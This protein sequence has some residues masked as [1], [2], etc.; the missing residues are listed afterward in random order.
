MP[1]LTKGA[2]QPKQV[3]VRLSFVR[4]ETGDPVAGLVVNIFAD[5]PKNQGPRL[6]SLQTDRAGYASYKF[7]RSLLAGN[8]RLTVA[9]G[10]S[11][12]Q[13]LVLNVADLLAGNDAH[14]IRLD[15][16][17][18]SVAT[19]GP[20]LGL[21]SVISP[22]PK[23]AALSPASVGLIPQLQAS[24]GLC[25]QLMPTTLDGRRFQAV[26]VVPDDI[27]NPT[28]LVCGDASPPL[29]VQIVTGKLLEYEIVWNPR[30]VVLGDLLNSITLA[31]C[32]QVNVAVADWMRRET[33]S[34][35]EDTQL[36]E[37]LYQQMDHDRLITEAMN[38]S[39]KKKSLSLAVGFSAPI[40]EKLNITGA[41]G[42]S[43]SSQDL[44]LNT[45]S[46]LSERITQAA[47]FVASRRSSV[48]FQ[49]TAS[50]QYKYQTRTIRNHNHCHTLTL[51]YYQV[52]RNYEVVTDYKGERDCILVKY[53]NN[54][55]D[56]ERA[57]CNAHLLKDA[58]LDPA[59]SGCFDELADALFCCDKETPPKEVRMDS[60]TITVRVGV[61][62]RLASVTIILNT[63]NGAI[64]FQPINALSWQSGGTYTQTLTLPGQ[65][66]PQKVTSI[67][68]NAQHYLGG[69]PP[70]LTVLESIEI[71]YHAVGYSVPFMLYSSQSPINI[72]FL[73]L[74]VK[75]E[76]PPT[77]VVGRNECVENSCCIQKLL[78]HL[79][80]HK[81]YYNTILWLNEDPDERVAR[82]S[83][84]KRDDVPLSLIAQIENM[85]VAV[86]GDFLVF[87]VAGSELVDNPSVAPVAEFVTM[88]T[89]GVY[90][91]GILGQ[92]DT[93]ER[94]DPDRFW[95]WKESPCP[96][97]APAVAPPP[98][99]QE[100]VQ[101]SDLKPDLIANLITLPSVPNV[102][103][104]GIKGLVTALLDSAAAGS[105]EAKALLDKLLDTIKAGLTP[106]KPTT[107]TG[108]K[109][110]EGG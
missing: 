59:L 58:L 10:G 51:M 9:Y 65:V 15:D 11:P 109:D 19:V 26:Q 80:C 25:A 83:C 54:D 85:P 72:E 110:K 7:D 91:E 53:D 3:A 107:K 75:A 13:T 56:A 97:S 93:C 45:T 78:G 73:Q 17:E 48:V 50:E 37:E 84:C 21:P 63:T 55:F 74:P 24:G 57:Y 30:G 89:P 94:I 86:Y 6:A 68:V 104:S 77:P 8:P 76:L 33:A 62:R 87:P 42:F 100:G 34:R 95:N 99:P 106:P 64:P 23:D 96:D 27:C 29:G 46:Q 41:F 82:W 35:T 60:L 49:T 44:A 67:I 103:E 52:N 32:E 28:Q 101:L 79:N 4:K 90:A 1:D 14:T 108:D 18:A 102:P 71:T 40:N 43:K 70:G 12:N 39:V 98:K 36:R 16:A 92:C 38:S 20:N 105:S 5:S 69:V 2:R 31:P 47:S 61:T 66:D 81:R 88:P 22:D